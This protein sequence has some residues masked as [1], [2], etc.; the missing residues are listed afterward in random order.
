VVTSSSKIIATILRLPTA[1]GRARAFST[2]YSPCWWYCCYGS[3]TVTRDQHP[4]VPLEL[5]NCSLCSMQLWF[6]C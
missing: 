6:L 4:C 2:C 1:K 5:T 3:A